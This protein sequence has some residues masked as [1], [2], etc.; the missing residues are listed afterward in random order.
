M[1][2]LIDC[3]VSQSDPL[4][5][6]LLCTSVSESPCYHVR[7]MAF[8]SVSLLLSAETPPPPTPQLS[9]SSVVWDFDPKYLSCNADDVKSVMD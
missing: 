6:H 1:S 7:H 9:E 3:P 5:L 4:S 8:S 2:L